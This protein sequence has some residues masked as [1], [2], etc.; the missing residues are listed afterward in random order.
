MYEH[1][2]T[3]RNVA[4][5]HKWGRGVNVIVTTVLFERVDV[6]NLGWPLNVLHLCHA[7]HINTP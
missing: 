4:V 6:V 5:S 1:E 7:I 2:R 3:P